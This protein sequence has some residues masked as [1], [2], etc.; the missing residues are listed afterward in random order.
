[1]AVS[2]AGDAERYVEIGGRRYAHI[3]DPATGL[4]VVDRAGVTVVAPD[5]ATADALDTAVYI[6]GPRRGLPLVESTPG[7][8]A[9]VVRSEP[10]GL[11]TF[12]SRLFATLPRARAGTDPAADAAP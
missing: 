9:Y 2:T 3:V 1:V 6:L 4:G 11:Q 7:A 8:A 12:Q 10:S 5:G